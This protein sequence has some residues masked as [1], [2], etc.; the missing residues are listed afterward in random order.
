MTTTTTETRDRI[1]D[2]REACE[3]MQVQAL[4]EMRPTERA[5]FAVA[6]A[7]HRDAMTKPWPPSQRAEAERLAGEFAWLFAAAVAVQREIG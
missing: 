6:A 3:A 1:T 4:G 2:W 5:A 7:T